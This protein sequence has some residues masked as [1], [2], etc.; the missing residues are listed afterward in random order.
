LK[1]QPFEVILLSL[2]LAFSQVVASSPMSYFIDFGNRISV[3]E[4]PIAPGSNRAR[5]NKDV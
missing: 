3:S 4:K 2:L 1:K 5:G